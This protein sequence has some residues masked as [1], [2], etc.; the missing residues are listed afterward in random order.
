MHSEFIDEILKLINNQ[1]NAIKTID[2]IYYTH[3][4]RRKK[5]R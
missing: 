2:I 1:R 3:Q 4:K 5:G